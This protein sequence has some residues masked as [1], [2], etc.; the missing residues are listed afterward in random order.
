[1]ISSV[2]PVGLE[3]LGKTAIQTRTGD[4]RSR[5]PARSDLHD[6]IEETQHFGSMFGGA[7]AD[8]ER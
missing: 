7:A 6:M 3:S 4:I 5:R 1:M 8:I 2:Y